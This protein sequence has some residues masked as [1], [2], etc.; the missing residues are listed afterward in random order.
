[1][2]RFDDKVMK[3]AYKYAKSQTAYYSKSF[4]LSSAMLPKEKRWDKMSRIFQKLAK[5]ITARADETLDEHGRPTPVPPSMD[6]SGMGVPA[7]EK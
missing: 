3:A 1:M 7:G 2:N 4:F 5:K 6:R